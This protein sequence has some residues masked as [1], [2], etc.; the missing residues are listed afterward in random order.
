MRTLKRRA[1]PY[2]LPGY[3]DYLAAL[4]HARGINTP[5][6]AAAYLK[7]A[8]GQLH[9]P[10][11]LQ[12]MQKACELIRQA[13]SKGQ[14]VAVYGDYD[15]DG[16]CASAILLEALKALGI[17]A[18]PYI[19]TRQEEGYG[20]N[21]EAVGLLSR[22]ARL[23]LSVDCGITAVNEVAL[24]KELGMAVIITDHHTLPEQLPAADAIIHPQLAAYPNP[25]LCGAGVAWK[26]A[27]ALLGTEAAWFS[28]DLAA[29]ATVADMVP[30]QGENRVMVSL[31]LQEMKTRRRQGLKALLKVAGIR[32]GAAISAEHVA[33][34]LAPR[35]NATGRLAD[36]QDALSLLLCQEEAEAALLADQMD[37]LNQQRRAIEQAALK[38]ASAQVAGMDLRHLRSIVVYAP[39]WNPGVVGL[40]A[41]K[42]VERWHYPAIALCRNGEGLSG[43]GR[44]AGP[45]DLYAALSACA[46]LL[47]R[48]GGH[49]MAAGLAL[50]E[51]NLPAF[52]AAFDEAVKAQ[53]G[54]EDLI[55]ETIYDTSLPLAQVSLD[56]IAK[57]DQMAPFGV[58]NPPP[59]F[60]MENLRV[61][62]ARAVGN[63]GAHLKLTLGEEGAVRE[64]IAF[65]MGRQARSLGQS[66]TLVS[67]VE[68]NE[69]NG[70]TSAQ[71]MVRALLPGDQAFVRDSLL[72]ARAYASLL[73]EAAPEAV[74]PPRLVQTD[75]LP[76]LQGHR[77]NLLV[78]FSHETA[79]ALQ[80]RYPNAQICMGQ[81][82][83]PRAFNAIVYA[84]DF[85]RHFAGYQRL[86]FA[87]GLPEGAHVAAALSATQAQEALVLPL[88]DA[89]RR[90]LS[91][92]APSL[93]ALR[94][95]YRRLR[96][97]QTAAFT[98]DPGKDFIALMI[99][100]QLGLVQL[101]QEGEFL[102]L[103]PLKK[104]EPANSPLYT[105]LVK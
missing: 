89:Q 55:P 11:L 84:P 98:E 30:L 8:A 68:R 46:P 56:T 25:E 41:G 75:S 105:A 10:F 16:V 80:A 3:P 1:T 26:L 49:T 52:V 6:E 69:F 77:G 51:E 2:Q 73:A 31:G 79:N 85:T 43:S 64:G 78:A 87:D 74:A 62:T 103:L 65:S 63:E 90:L 104:I 76:T 32:E 5:E 54:G 53:L 42:L 95:V 100:Q 15:A 59:L 22:Q 21:A 28:L 83:D 9:D 45:V 94:A 47:T 71:L 67:S 20:I 18:I 93:D 50:M 99:F 92:F 91:Q 36:A 27:C 14:V 7:P 12:D 97:G 101:N 61:V 70:K 60:L 24:A 33:Y 58:G 57:L 82:T 102:R 23:L 44:S 17:K 88:S 13:G 39:D 19:P 4:L 38:E 37:Q 81:A 29:L 35:L 72:E 96:Q 34:Q 40:T 66:V 48:F 86:I